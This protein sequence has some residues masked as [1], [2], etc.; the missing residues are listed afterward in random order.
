[1][2]VSPSARPN[3][4]T[5]PALA[6]DAIGGEPVAVV[7]GE[8]HVKIFTWSGLAEPYTVDNAQ[9]VYLTPGAAYLVGEAIAGA[10][11]TV[12]NNLLERQVSGID[13]LINPKAEK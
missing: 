6:T 10:A 5:H 1:M 7:A 2:S 9:V 3:D 8:A 4:N 11:D 12:I 13:N